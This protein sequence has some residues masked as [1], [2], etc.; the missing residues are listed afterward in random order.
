MYRLGMKCATDI[1]KIR[2]WPDSGAAQICTGKRGEF[3]QQE[4]HYLN[5][6]K[7]TVTSYGWHG[8]FIYMQGTRACMIQ[9]VK[10]MEVNV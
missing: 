3:F 6:Q 9:H 1:V 5:I 2:A 10:T 8:G 7:Q 4:C